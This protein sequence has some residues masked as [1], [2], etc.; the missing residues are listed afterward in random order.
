MEF[1]KNGIDVRDSEA[2]K[3]TIS[4]GHQNRGMC[5]KKYLTM[6]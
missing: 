2:T 1:L 3:K 6:I 5:H 4:N